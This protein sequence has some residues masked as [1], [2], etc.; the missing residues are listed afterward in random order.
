MTSEMKDGKAVVPQPRVAVVMATYNGERYL[1]EQVESIFLQD[2]ARI[3]LYVYDDCSTDSTVTQLRDMAD[4]YQ[5]LG[6]DIHV[7][8]GERNVGFPTS[9]FRALDSV[10]SEYD[11][12]AYSDQDDVWK[13]GKIASGIA[14]LS[15]WAEP[16]VLGLYFE[17]TTS[18]D[19]QLNFLF[20]RDLSKL[21]LTL[22]SFFVRARVAAHT[23]IF[24]TPMK[25][26]ICRMGPSHYGFSHGW[27]A[28]LVAVAA[29]ARIV[30]GDT[31][32]T[33][34]RRLT[35]SVSAG[36]KGLAR[37]LAFE[38][39]V[40]FNP[41]VNRVPMSELLLETY[42]ES[43]TKEETAFLETLS[44]YRDNVGNRIRMLAP[45]NYCTDIPLANLEAFFSILSGR[46]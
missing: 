45:R 46:Y 35:S 24:N 19:E 30:V 37:R 23:M 25:L 27:I 43:L 3:S 34:H 41:E 10:D 32:H 44:R 12:Y 6:Y 21:N 17:P 5:E 15:N 14:A 13:Q 7:K 28:L 33:L 20:E 38:R 16:D 2:G 26:E 8:V 1:R 36:G 40:I 42:N 39:N 31:S 29:K 18:V 11:Y 9:F 4:E 22:Q